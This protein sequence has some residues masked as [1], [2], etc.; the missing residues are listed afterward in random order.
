MTV[1]FYPE[2]QRYGG[3][4]I[5]VDT[6]TSHSASCGTYIISP[7]PT[8]VL[9]TTYALNS[10]SKY[11]LWLQ[12]MWLYMYSLY[13]YGSVYLSFIDEAYVCEDDSALLTDSDMIVVC[14]SLDDVF[15]RTSPVSSELPRLSSVL[16]FELHNSI[17]E[18]NY[19]DGEVHMYMHGHTHIY[20]YIGIHSYT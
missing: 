13:E 17:Y 12:S 6:A 20:T 10:S 4:G 18:E 2:I 15:S 8:C 1:Q 19:I 16:T 14:P 7:S 5:C 9:Q 11:V 3:N